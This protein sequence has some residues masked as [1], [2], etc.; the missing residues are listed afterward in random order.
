MIPLQ[1]QPAAGNQ[2]KSS[3]C[4][5]CGPGRTIRGMEQQAIPIHPRRARGFT[6]VELL[7]VIVIIAVLAAV[8]IYATRGIRDKANQVKALNSIR[9]VGAANVA[10]SAEN[11]GDINVLLYDGDAR[12]AGGYITKSF[13]G[14]LT[15]FLFTGVNVANNKASSNEMKQ[16]LN[17]LLST[18]DCSTMAGTFQQNVKIYHD[19]SGLPMP[20]AFNSYVQGWNTYRKTSSFD[21]SQTLYFTYGFSNFNE[22][23][24]S[25]YT[26]LPNDGVTRLPGIHYF[27]NKSGVF[28]FL[29][30]HTE[31]I[32]PPIPKR[33]LTSAP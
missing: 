12:Q 8:A 9:Q 27:K 25:E 29:D 28:V 10:Y 31:I 19:V 7:V 14:R 2:E 24:G 26:P 1:T 32:S 18:T 30:G 6:L 13:W 11:N 15:P 22:T 20:F 16:S 4:V 3:V 21:T 23:K 33:K 17:A 5:R